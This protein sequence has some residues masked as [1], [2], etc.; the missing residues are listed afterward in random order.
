MKKRCTQCNQE[1]LLSEFGKHYG[2]DYARPSCRECDRKYSRE[3]TRRNLEKT[4][5][6][7]R[8]YMARARA[9]AEGAAR[10][11]AIARKS[12]NRGGRER[13]R[14]YLNR[15]KETDFFKWKA[16]QSHI[17][18]SDKQLR[19]LWG[20]Q[21]GLCALTGRPLGENPQLDHIIPKTRGGDD[22]YEN[23]RWLC[24]EANQSKRNLLDS[25]FIRLCRETVEW[26]ERVESE[27][28]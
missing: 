25:E 9:T 21:Q 23:S 17:S 3:Y 10:Q 19:Q 20:E 4:R 26:T 15:L 28:L 22:S 16:R 12:W 24:F 18:L 8:E 27:T 1:K 2:V 13:H 7:G 5:K 11:R 14:D 6:K